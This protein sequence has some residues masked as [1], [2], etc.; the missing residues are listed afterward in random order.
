MP[1][2]SSTAVRPAAASSESRSASV[3]SGAQSTGAARSRRVQALRR[4][5]FEMR[6]PPLVIQRHFRHARHDGRRISR[7]HDPGRQ[8][9]VVER[10]CGQRFAALPVPE[11]ERRGALREDDVPVG[12]RL[13]VG[14]HVLGEVVVPVEPVGFVAA[15]APVSRA[16]AG[17]RALSAPGPRSGRPAASC[18][19]GWSAGPS[20]TTPRC[21]RA[22]R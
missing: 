12:R 22:P 1:P 8:Q 21:R 10:D 6:E 13:V 14:L 15:G 2:A 9:V 19:A 16:D 4:D 17:R 18:R 20:R 7:F 5:R 3:N 11:L